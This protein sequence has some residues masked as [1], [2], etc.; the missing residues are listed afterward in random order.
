[1]SGGHLELDVEEEDDLMMLLDGIA[2]IEV[3]RDYVGVMKFYD[4][5]SSSHN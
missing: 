5:V 3:K 2:Q 1:M 4:S